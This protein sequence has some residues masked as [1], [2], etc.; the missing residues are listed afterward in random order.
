[1]CEVRASLRDAPHS[2][3]LSSPIRLAENKVF[4]ATGA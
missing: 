2:A 3:S 4:A 1:M